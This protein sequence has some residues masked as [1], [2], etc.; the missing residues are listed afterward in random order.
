MKEKLSIIGV[1]NKE[2]N[3]ETLT[4][5]LSATGLDNIIREQGPFTIFAPTDEAFKNL[6]AFDDLSKSE[7]NQRLKELL[8]LHLVQG[9]LMSKD[10]TKQDT[11][12][13]LAGQ[14]LEI[15]AKDG[16]KI[17]QAKIEKPDIEASNGVIH[18]ID[19]VL[20]PQTNLQTASA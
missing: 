4:K 16:L 19:N 6:S 8:A 12:K 2:G 7:S 17:N 13:T 20:M 15:D 3:F 1:A 18:V 10:L 11:V 9:K 5:A 14:N